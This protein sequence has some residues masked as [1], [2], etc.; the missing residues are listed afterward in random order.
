DW[1]RFSLNASGSLSSKE[2]FDFEKKPVHELKILACRQSNCSS[3]HVFISVNDRNDNCP[4]FP[5]QDFHLSLPENDRSPLPRQI[6]RIPAALDGDFHADNTKVC[7]TSESPLFFFL[8]PTLPVLYTNQSFDR[9]QK[10]EHKFKITAYD[11]HLACRDLH[12][13]TN[14]SITGI[15]TVKDV[16]DNFPKFSE[17]KYYATV[18]QG[19]ASPGS[20]LAKVSATDPDE[21]K[22]GLPP[23]SIDP[24]TGELSANEALRESSYSFTVTVTDGANHD[25]SASVVGERVCVVVSVCTVG[26]ARLNPWLADR[27]KQPITE[28]DRATL[29][30]YTTPHQWEDSKL[31]FY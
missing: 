30:M 18:I 22:Q 8:E 7:Y 1:E 28:L 31:P 9:E 2:P 13:S 17:K 21:E 25:D 24:K 4:I 3:V 15:L 23:I 6:G 16:N 19:H 11:C 14:G 27:M 26:A 20:H 12:K 10:A 5:K 29:S